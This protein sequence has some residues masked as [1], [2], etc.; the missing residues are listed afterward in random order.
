M[1][2]LNHSLAASR[3]PNPLEIPELLREILTQIN[4]RVGNNLSWDENKAILINLAR[5]ARVA[6]TWASPALDILWHTL[7]NVLPILNLLPLVKAGGVLV[8]PFLILA[9]DPLISVCIS[10][11]GTTAHSA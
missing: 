1:S 7:E 10:G 5:C 11:A 2:T 8:N 9:N 3:K 6:K 4:L